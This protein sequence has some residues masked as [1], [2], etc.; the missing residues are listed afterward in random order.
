MKKILLFFIFWVLIFLWNIAFAN[1]EITSIMPNTSDDKNLEYI[2]ITNN[3]PEKID[4]TWYKIEDKSWSN[5][6]IKN[7]TLESNKS[8]KFYYKTTNIRLNNTNEELKLF[9]NKN[10]LIDEIKYS[11]SKKNQIIFI[12]ELEKKII[13]WEKYIPEKK[14]EINRG[15]VVKKMIFN[16]IFAIFIFVLVYFFAIKSSNENAH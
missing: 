15:E 12:K 14:E 1:V 3:N 9:D 4:I 2:E 6:V 10:N 11:S 8:H 7:I 5:F 13:A 16:M